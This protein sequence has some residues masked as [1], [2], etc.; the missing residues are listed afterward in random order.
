MTVRHIILSL[1]AS[2]ALC[3]RAMG[4][5]GEPPWTADSHRLSSSE[6]G[7]TSEKDH[8]QN[9]STVTIE[10]QRGILSDRVHGYVGQLTRD[11]R[12]YDESVARW[13]VP[14]CFLVFGRP[15][16]QGEF[17]IGQLSE[18]ATAAGARVAAQ[19]CHPN[20]YVIFTP[21]AEPVVNAL[22][23][24]DVRMFGGASPAD[25][26]GF[27]DSSKPA[28]IRAWYNIEE[29]GPGG[30]PFNAGGSCYPAAAKRNINCQFSASRLRLDAVLQLS[31]TI[32]FVDVDRVKG[33]ELGPVAN[34]IAMAVLSDLNLNADI[35][36]A[37]TIL[38][39]F[40]AAP[41]DRPSGLSSWDRA[42]LRAVYHSEQE[43]KTQRGQ[44]EVRMLQDIPK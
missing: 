29:V 20:V 16:A 40:T 10:G 14:L 30:I 35:G 28:P 15:R 13:R 4:A 25:I 19:G 41:A 9:R 31:S 42:F 8:S 17:V 23:D 22:Y 44:I 24:R 5:Q 18:V 36:D 38:R 11:P 33:F 12:F 6:A 37:P 26:K 34:Y 1:T 32:I 39:L 27:L 43:S 21:Q 7:D 2:I 3:C